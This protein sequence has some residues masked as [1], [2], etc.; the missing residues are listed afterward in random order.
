MN[1]HV[2]F[3]PELFNRYPAPPADPTF[4]PIPWKNYYDFGDPIGYDLLPTRA[5][6][7]ES[8]WDRFFAFRDERNQDDI[9]FTRYY[10]P[11]AAHN[12][13]WQDHHVFGHFI[14]EVVDRTN[15]VLPAPGRRDTG[16]PAHTCSPH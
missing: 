16:R 7:K 8:G 1:K 14:E 4:P 10:F 13:Y 2:R 11:G 5:W 12:D 6:M 3:W 15:T 9:G